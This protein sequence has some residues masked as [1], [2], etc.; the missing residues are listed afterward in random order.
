M[1]ICFLKQGKRRRGFTI[2]EALVA[3]AILMIGVVEPLYVASKNVTN[4]GTDKNMAIASYLAQEGMEALR[5]TRDNDS[6]AG[7][8]LGVSAGSPVLYPFVCSGGGCSTQNTINIQVGGPAFAAN[9][10]APFIT[11]DNANYIYKQVCDTT[12]TNS[13]FTR[14]FTLTPSTV[15]AGDTQAPGAREVWAT[16]VVSWI[17]RGL[18]YSYTLKNSFF[19]N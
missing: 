13:I 5:N 7:N 8:W 4:A 2:V 16:V 6:L 10:T 12:C 11:I 15:P 18:A 9:G 17:E 3:I 14:T 1:S 19:R